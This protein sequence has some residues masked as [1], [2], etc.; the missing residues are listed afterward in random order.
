MGFFAVLFKY[1]D[2]LLFLLYNIYD[3]MSTLKKR[4]KV[5]NSDLNTIINENFSVTHAGLFQSEEEW[6]HPRR[7]IDDFEI[8]F[9]TD[10]EIFMEEGDR[11]IYA[12]KGQLFILRP[13]IPH[14][15]TRSSC[16]VSFYWFHFKIKNGLPFEQLMFDSFED[17][18]LFKELLHACYLPSRPEF[19]VNSVFAHILGKLCQLSEEGAGSFDGTAEKIYQWIRMNA[20]ADLTVAA[21]AERFNYSPDHLSRI[22]KSRFKENAGEI[23]NHFL[24]LRAK[25]L[26]SHTS[27]YVK[28]I[29]ADLRFKDDKAFIGY[30]KYHEGVSP[31]EFRRRYGKIYM[32]NR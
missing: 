11:Q 8:V 3:A 9:V 27:K 21:V 12:K 14:G 28:E 16:G 23:I 30:F 29:A 10:G 26:L 15:G 31:T 17:S 25:E 20:F 4:Q 13:H 2:F 32:N 18:Y 22:C 24:M 7:T 5:G 1:V 6:I 19:L